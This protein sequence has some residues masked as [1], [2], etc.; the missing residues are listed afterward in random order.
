MYF[1]CIPWITFFILS[2][3]N[4]FKFAIKSKIRI[5]VVWQMSRL[6]YRYDGHLFAFL[7]GHMKHTSY[8]EHIIV[9]VR[10]LNY[11]FDLPDMLEHVYIIDKRE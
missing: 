5:Q 1:F 11:S 6:I 8:W 2:Y 4:K 10:N 9:P 3:N 7:E